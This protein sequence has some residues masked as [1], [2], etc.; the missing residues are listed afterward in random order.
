MQDQIDNLEIEVKAKES[1][2]KTMAIAQSTFELDNLKKTL[3]EE[4]SSIKKQIS[5]V[6]NSLRDKILQV[7]KMVADVE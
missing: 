7:T 5:D 6:D 2:Q 4:T 3:G 1:A